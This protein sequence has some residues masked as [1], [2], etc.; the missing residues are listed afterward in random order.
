MH[1]LFVHVDVCFESSPKPVVGVLRKSDEILQGHVP[2]GLLVEA[3]QQ[4]IHDFIIHSI[5]HLHFGQH[6]VKLTVA[7]GAFFVHVEQLEGLA[8][9][10]GVVSHIATGFRPD[11]ALQFTT[12][13]CIRSVVVV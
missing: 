5:H 13:L 6:V 3:A 2:L 7:D 11:Q 10:H 12:H 1:H 4:L 8:V 9:V